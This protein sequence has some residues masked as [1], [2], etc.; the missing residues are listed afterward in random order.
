MQQYLEQLIDDIHK[1]TWNIKP[2]HAIW[3][4]SEADP[5]NELELDDI[6]YVE[7]FIYGTPLP[8]AHITGIESNLL[9]PPEKLSSEQQGVI[10]VELEKLLQ[11]HNFY[12]DFPS[13]YPDYLKY[14]FILTF[15]NESHVPLT[16][17]EN[18]I[19]L[20]DYDETNCPFEGY[21]ISCAEVSAQMKFDE[22]EG[23]ANGWNLMEFNNKFDIKSLIPSKEDVD[24][25][26]RNKKQQ[27]NKN[28]NTNTNSPEV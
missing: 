9:P 10:A 23:K 11:I 20:C 4:E 27:I 24:E 13:G 2:P 16:F 22:E 15:W 18:H 28:R 14:P 5:L 19:E 1:A 7:E 25:F 12:L 3:G 6:S 17:G 8:I 21:C 26:L